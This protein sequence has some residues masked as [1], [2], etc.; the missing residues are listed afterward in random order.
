MKF[1]ADIM[2]GKLAKY[3]RMAGCD[4]LYINDISDDEIIKIAR[5]TGRTVLT[6]DSLM[7]TRKEFK[8]GVIKYLLIKDE[9]LKNQLEQVK[10]D[11]NLSL[12]PNLI[13]CIECNR[14][15]IK[16]EKKKIKNKVP[17][18]V[19]KT[20]QNFLYCKNCDKY[21]WR[22][23]HYRNIKNTFLDIEK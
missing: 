18:Y 4:V 15:L 8:N 11:L 23:T 20:Q 9:K 12:R 2:V 21:Y 10:T 5:E 3:L 6:R 7:L 1:I 14:K 13:R 17:P 19:Y 22:G 16:V